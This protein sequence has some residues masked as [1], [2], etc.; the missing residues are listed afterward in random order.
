MLRREVVAHLPPLALVAALPA[1]GGR[2]R[3]GPRV[4]VGEV[5]GGAEGAPGAGHGAQR[6]RGERV[7]GDVCG[8]EGGAASA[9]DG[10]VAEVAVALE[11]RGGLRA[12]AGGAGH[13]EAAA[14]GLVEG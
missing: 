2:Q 4:R 11:A 5:R 3:A 12:A 7:A 10:R 6:A 8:V 1:R 9:G 14:A 13:A